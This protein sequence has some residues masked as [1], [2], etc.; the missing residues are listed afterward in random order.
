MAVLAHNIVKS[1]FQYPPSGTV[2]TGDNRG[3]RP[4]DDLLDEDMRTKACEKYRMENPSVYSHSR[5]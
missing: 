2:T 4:K 3:S 5:M 1:A